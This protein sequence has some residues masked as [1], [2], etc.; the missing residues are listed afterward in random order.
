MNVKV[1]PV[2]DRDWRD[3]NR[4]RTEVLPDFAGVIV[5]RYGNLFSF[6]DSP[7]LRY[8][9]KQ[10]F[11]Y[12]RFCQDRLLTR[13]V[14][15]RPAHVGKP[16]TFLYYLP[17][18]DSLLIAGDTSKIDSIYPGGYH[19]VRPSQLPETFRIQSYTH[20]EFTLV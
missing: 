3:D 10:V 15:S 4:P 18:S 13:L 2:G 20:L 1:L 19:V 8:A 12:S 9:L 17:S 16:A 6:A 14:N 5:G 7:A 11:G